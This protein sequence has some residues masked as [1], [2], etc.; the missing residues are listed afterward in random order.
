[1]TEHKHAALIKA[2]AEG[3]KIQKFS[4]RTQAWEESANPTWN[5]ET[6]YRLRI[7]PDYVIELNAHVLNG[8][9]FI[10]VLARFPNLSLVFDAASN[11]LKSVEMI[12]W[13]GKK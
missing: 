4:K 3:A 13:K 1:M 10:D 8:E 5:E 9:L 7:K 11:E 2:W 6:E 12:N